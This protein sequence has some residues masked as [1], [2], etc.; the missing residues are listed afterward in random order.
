[1]PSNFPCDFYSWMMCDNSLFHQPVWLL[2]SFNSADIYYANAYGRQRLRPG[3]CLCGSRSHAGHQAPP[4]P[5]CGTCTSCVV[6]YS[7]L[8]WIPSFLYLNRMYYRQDPRHKPSGGF[9]CRPDIVGNL[10][11]GFTGWSWLGKT[12]FP[13]MFFQHFSWPHYIFWKMLEKP[14]KQ[15]T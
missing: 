14:G 9:F 2:C 5:A 8:A 3:Q 11:F 12:Y 7:A 15:N 1:M 10:H 6:L 4:L 13:G